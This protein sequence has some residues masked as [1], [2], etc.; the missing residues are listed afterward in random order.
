MKD[1]IGC[2][3][4]AGLIIPLINAAYYAYVLYLREKAGA[5]GVA[6][7]P[8]RLYPFAAFGISISTLLTLAA[9]TTPGLIVVAF[10]G[11]MQSRRLRFGAL[12]FQ[13]PL[14]I[15]LLCIA[16]L[17]Y[18]QYAALHFYFTLFQEPRLIGFWRTVLALP[19]LTGGLLITG[20][21]AAGVG[22]LD[23]Y[24]LYQISERARLL[25]LCIRPYFPT[26]YRWHMDRNLDHTFDSPG[27]CDVL[28]IS[29]LHIWSGR[30]ALESG[31]M[32][33]DTLAEWLRG[34]MASSEA[35]AVVLLGDLTDT[36]A[37]SEWDAARA[38]LGAIN[39]PILGIPGN[40][41]LHF[42][43][44]QNQYPRMEGRI[45][46]HRERVLSQYRAISNDVITTDYPVLIPLENIPVDILLLDSNIRPSSSPLTNAIGFVGPQQLDAA[47]KRC[48]G[49]DAAR[50][51]VVSLHHHIIP[52]FSISAPLL[53][54][55]D[56]FRVVELAERH[57]AALVAHGHTHMP[58]VYR[59]ETLT[60][61][62]C[63]SATFP[64]KGSP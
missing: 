5:P 25:W 34:V 9:Y 19:R 50:H 36:G 11:R 48:E 32:R 57:Q 47:N 38:I 58:Y 60:I 39:V 17:F 52:P 51:L 22:V 62:S 45:G 49:R 7:A 26:R 35:S 59:S 41:D 27:K 29:D 23:V 13:Q 30:N 56:F 40:H 20:V 15:A 16:L 44:L 54:C 37:N 12:I 31:A 10:L 42:E 6:L 64:A 43:S 61:L 63:G 21:L 1:L 46:D 33:H 55:L 8:G 53:V 3:M 28:F 14:A 2:G 24:I 18:T 4:V